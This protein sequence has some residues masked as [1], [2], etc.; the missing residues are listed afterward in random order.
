MIAHPPLAMPLMEGKS[1]NSHGLLDLGAWTETGEE[2]TTMRESTGMAPR[3]IAVAGAVAALLVA[4]PA[5]GAQAPS[6]GAAKTQDGQSSEDTGEWSGTP[7][8]EWDAVKSDA[9]RLVFW[10]GDSTTKFVFLVDGGKVTGKQAYIECGRERA[11][12]IMARGL[13]ADPEDN[14]V[15]ARADGTIVVIDYAESEYSGMS[16]D[17]VRNACRDMR[18]VV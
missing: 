3:G 7:S 8:A 1:G 2:G 11:A 5:C 4:L 14:V 12:L 13:S 18:E 9:T 6:E 10:D 16:G 17:D 15:S